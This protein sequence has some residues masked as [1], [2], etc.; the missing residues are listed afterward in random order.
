MGRRIYDGK[1]FVY[2]YHFANQCSELMDLDT[3][4]DIGSHYEL[5][6]R[7][8]DEGET[9]TY[10]TPYYDLKSWEIPKLI[11]LRDKILKGKTMNDINYIGMKAVRHYIDSQSKKWKNTFNAPGEKERD[12]MKVYNSNSPEDW[13][14][15]GSFQNGLKFEPYKAF[16]EGVKNELT[17]SIY[18]LNMVN[19][20]VEHV[21]KEDR[22]YHFQDE[23]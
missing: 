9:Y 20:L 21:S 2:K 17:E 4:Y 7:H 8:Q 10:E 13:P 1:E 12:M 6:E 3:E 18:F 16:A 14:F 5:R 15:Y 19:A 22:D 23:Y 11:E